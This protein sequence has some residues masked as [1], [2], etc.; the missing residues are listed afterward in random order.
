MFTDQSE[1]ETFQA[2]KF[3][4]ERAQAMTRLLVVDE[5]PSLA[6]LLQ[7]KL[8]SLKGKIDWVNTRPD[9]LK[10]CQASEY[11]VIVV[12]PS[13]AF[14]S[15]AEALLLIRDSQ[16]TA[17]SPIIFVADDLMMS[18]NLWDGQSCD[19]AG[20]IDVI[21]KPVPAGLLCSK[22]RVFTDLYQTRQALQAERTLVNKQQRDFSQLIKN[23]YSGAE[24]T[25]LSDQHKITLKMLLKEVFC[26]SCE[27]KEANFR[28][29]QTNKKLNDFSHIASHDLQ[30]PLRTITNFCRLLQVDI[31][32]QNAALVQEDIQFIQ[33]A[34]ERMKVLI[35]ALLDFARS[36]RQ[37][38]T[39]GSV[40]LNDCLSIVLSQHQQSIADRSAAIVCPNELPV[41]MGD[42]IQLTQ[43]FQNLISNSIKFCAEDSNPAL[44]IFTVPS[45][46]GN[47]FVRV[48]FADN[49]IGIEQQFHESIFQP[50]QRLHSKDL[51]PGSGIGLATVQNILARHGGTISVESKL[52]GGSKFI[53]DLPKVPSV[54]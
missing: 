34:A 49:G 41:I 19:G 31:E 23:L 10:K 15:A 25:Q 44:K 9:L 48:C 21:S 1:T 13:L 33:Q 20:Y 7:D 22:V 43:I 3:A 29:E 2:R 12:D 14:L 28:L 27:L 52:G 18:E 42:K 32:R 6:E 39:L 35:N 50:F 8:G 17:K 53:V 5:S 36:E 54:D 16:K 45:P 4:V 51:Y 40:N 11:A 38:L 37:P 47:D 24:A 46:R 26:P 30:E